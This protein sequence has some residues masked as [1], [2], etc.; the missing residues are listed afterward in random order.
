ME[1]SKIVRSYIVR[2][3]DFNVKQKGNGHGGVVDPSA[4]VRRGLLNEFSIIGV[5]RGSVT[6]KGESGNAK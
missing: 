5:T 6:Y 4:F 1:V 3:Q 2:R